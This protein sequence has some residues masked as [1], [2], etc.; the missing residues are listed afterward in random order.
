M[1]VFN[2]LILSETEYDKEMLAS[3][4]SFHEYTLCQNGHVRLMQ[5]R[6]IFDKD[7]S[8]YHLISAKVIPT[9]KDQTPEG[10]RMYSLWF[11]LIPKGSVYSAFCTC[12]GGADQG[13]R[14]L[15]AALFELDDFLSKERTSV[16]SLPAY[17]NPKPMPETRPLPFMEMKMAHSTWP[18]SKR[19]MTNYDDSWIDSFD[20]VLPK[21][22]IDFPLDKQIDVAKKLR[23]IDSKSGILDYLPYSGT[24]CTDSSPDSSPHSSPDSSE[25]EIH[26]PIDISHMTI[27]S[28]A[29]EFA[30]DNIVNADN[31]DTLA[32]FF[33]QSVNVTP[34][35]INLV[36]VATV[37]QHKNDNWHKMRHLLVTGKKI[38]GLYTRKKTIE[39]NPAEDVS[40]TVQ[41][42]IAPKPLKTYPAAIQYGINHEQDAKDASIKIMKKKHAN[43]T[44][45]EPGLMLSE[46]H[47]WVGA[48]PDSIRKCACCPDTLLEIKCP[49]KGADMNPKEALLLE[50]VGANTDK[51]GN[52][53][54]KAAHL[55][56][57]QI[58]TGMAVCGL[59]KCDFVVF[60]RKGIYIVP[61]NF[62]QTFWNST[63]K[64]VKTFYTKNIISAVLT[65]I[66]TLFYYNIL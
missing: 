65:Q 52:C 45:E 51:D 53:F 32:Q 16:T 23:A 54:L 18:N 59:T 57:F 20:P 10:D 21:Q 43:L 46:E 6:I 39:K 11:I 15:D 56:Y 29:E 36:N 3:W 31:I 42:F 9:Q 5:N 35:E 25:Y 47:G 34:E 44:I 60:T 24:T 41:N 33:V 4:R 30:G 17:W 22:R 37:G 8:K 61:V 7:D 58:Q 50:T 13:C 38:K 63:I 2:H 19:V 66:Y 12:K 49:Y 26:V 40:K 27:S 1:D 62:D 55:H 48:S 28:R 64:T 14:P